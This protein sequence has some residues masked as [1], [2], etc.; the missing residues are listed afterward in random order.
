MEELGI[1]LWCFAGTCQV[2]MRLPGTLDVR[3]ESESIMVRDGCARFKYRTT[4]GGGEH[5]MVWV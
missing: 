5:V 1:D 3:V 4:L 2:W